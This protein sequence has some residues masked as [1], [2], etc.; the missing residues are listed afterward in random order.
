MQESIDCGCYRETQSDL[1]NSVMNHNMRQPPRTT[2]RATRIIASLILT[3]SGITGSS[4]LLLSRAIGEASFVALVVASLIVGLVILFE[5]RVSSF[6]LKNGS[7]DLAKIEETRIEV[8]AKRE[9]IEKLAYLTVRLVI[10]SQEAQVSW[11][12]T[13]E[14]EVE[15][16][17]IA[18]EILTTAG[19]DPSDSI[20]RKIDNI[21]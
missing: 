3:V 6:N 1:T 13:K 10:A 14:E 20:F 5:N 15:F 8:E 16:Q 17:S 7:I 18:K 4:H 2:S 9:E 12:M 21:N 11:G 19:T